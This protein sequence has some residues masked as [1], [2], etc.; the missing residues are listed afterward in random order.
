MTAVVRA[1]LL[2]LALLGAFASQGANAQDFERRLPKPPPQPPMPE[3][4]VPPEAPPPA[5]D[6][7]QLVPELKGLVFVNGPGAVQPEG[8]APESV[9]GGIDTR[10]APLI[11]TTGAS[12]QLRAY[13]GRPLTRGD[14]NTIT[15]LVQEAYRAAERPFVDVSVPPQKVQSG[16]I[17]IVVTEYRVGEINV[18]G[19]RHFSTDLIRGMGDL[20]PGDPLTLP[21]LRKALDG[22][23]R[24][25][26]LTVN[27]IVQPGDT[28]GTTDVVLEAKDRFPL[29]V[30]GGYDNQ[31]VETLG[32]DE[33]FVGFNWGNVLG[34][35]QILS[36]Q[37]TR[38]FE[39]RYAS[40]SV[41]DVIPLSPDDRILLFG[42]YA[43]QKPFLS[44]VFDS[45][46]HSA[47]IS[48][49][50][51]SDLPMPLGVKSSIQFGVDYKRT[52]NNLEFLGFRLL[53]TAVEVFQFP[54]IFTATIEDRLGQTILE[55]QFVL[56][57][58][59]ITKYNKDEYMRL[60][61]PF[62][63]ASY[64][65]D[66]ASITRVTRLPHNFSWIVRGMVQF[67]TGNLPYSEQL[68]AGGIGSVRGYD[69][70][71]ALGSEGVMLKTEIDAPAFSV[72]SKSGQFADQLQLG[73]FLDYANL[74]QQRRLPDSPRN[75]DLASIGAS[76]H[77]T[78]GRYLDVELELG[79]QLMHAPFQPDR[80]TRLAVTVTVG[81]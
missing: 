44:S 40:H 13:L 51:V 37:Y 75:A 29:R 67:A 64:G 74:W 31:G 45:E 77:Y 26:F 66:R 35:G 21:R 70:N 69:P 12:D 81:L 1:S 46:G 27:S 61:V 32:R 47:Q 71:T 24:N 59:N 42:A 48:G 72:L 33:W 14:L 2:A 11:A 36:Y 5:Q 3:V 53:D 34:T 57:P 41:S 68:A 43:T 38:S 56:S 23:N 30:Y 16:V 9:A 20:E 73:I 25:P 58:G 19:N 52:D 60:L 54:L 50:F 6:A 7:T 79:H 28:T 62:S 49:R 17:Q 63:D 22:Y 15:R 76:L 10:A 4:A 8:V 39:G 65:Y 18:T 78:V 55:N 80:K